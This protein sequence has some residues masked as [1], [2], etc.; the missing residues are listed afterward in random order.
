MAMTMK[1]R[2]LA[3]SS[4]QPVDRITY[5]CDAIFASTVKR[6]LKEG[7]PKECVHME[8]GR[9]PGVVSFGDYFGCDKSEGPGLNVNLGI[10]PAFEYKMICEDERTITAQ[11]GLGI[12]SKSFKENPE[13]SMHHY[14]EHPVKDR[15]SWADMKRRYNP[16]TPG[17]LPDNWGDKLA[18][19]LNQATH[20][21]GAGSNGLFWTCRDW[22]GAEGLMYM[23]YDDPAMIED[24]MDTLV[25]LY[26]EV[27]TPVVKK[28]QLH[29]F[30]LSEDMS[31]KN[32]SLISPEMFSKFMAPRYRRLTD[33]LHENGVKHICVDS[34]GLIDDLIPLFLNCG[35]NALTPFEIQCGNDPVAVRKKYGKDLIIHG[36][37]NKHELAKDK[38]AIETEMYSKVP[39]LIEQGGYFPGLDHAVPSDVSFENF[40]YYMELKRKI[41]GA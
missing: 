6:W 27:L 10:I 30:G 1:E 2:F 38:K 20:P 39:W 3:S 19:Q 29:H 22:L 37:I 16:L 28:V 4:F 9:I 26:I 23:M 7:L 21:I 40:C 18:E 13:D 8:N 31:Y 34:D 15:D 35:V 5:S 24:M 14:L 41:I 17:R 25:D 36:G 12:I 33:F 32:G 11:D